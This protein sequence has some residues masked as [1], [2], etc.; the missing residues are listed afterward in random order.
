MLNC[1]TIATKNFPNI[2]FN[3]SL[4]FHVHGEASIHSY[5]TPFC[6]FIGDFKQVQP[7]YC[8][9]VIVNFEHVFYSREFIFFAYTQPAITCSKLTIETVEQVMKY[10]QS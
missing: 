3:G 9:N 1:I 5:S 7:K 4:S 10:V 2:N 8:G 6:C